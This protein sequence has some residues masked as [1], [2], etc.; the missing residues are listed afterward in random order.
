MYDKYFQVRS[1]TNLKTGIHNVKI[2]SELWK[3][4]GIDPNTTPN[5]MTLG[6]IGL[7]SMFVSE[8]QKEFKRGFNYNLTSNQIKSFTIGLLRDFETGKNENFKYYF[9]E[10][11]CFRQKISKYSFIIPREPYTKLN[12]VIEGR[13]IYFMPPMEITFSGYDEFAKK[14]DRPVI[15]LNWTRDVSKCETFEEVNQY[16]TDLLKKLEPKGDYDLV[17]CLDGALVVASQVINGRV[18]KGVIVDIVEDDKY[19]NDKINEEVALELAFNLPI[20][21]PEMLRQNLKRDISAETETSIKI[22]RLVDDI[23]DFAGNALIGTDLEDIIKIGLKRALIVWEYRLKKKSEFGK[24]LKELI[25]KKWA[26]ISGKLHVIKAFEFD[27]VGDIELKVN[28]SRDIY[29]LPDDKVII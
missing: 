22:K 18:R 15:G 2:I 11:N 26:E 21:M 6:E 10:L 16:F 23:K 24:K 4:M 13:P 7:E 8:I 1:T 17:G 12:H 27:K 28:T 25:G 20:E 3:N 19:L 29:L 14:F 5:H 9:D